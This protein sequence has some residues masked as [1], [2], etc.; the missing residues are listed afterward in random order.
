MALDDWLDVYDAHIPEHLD[1]MQE[2]YGAWL[3][4]TGSVASR[5]D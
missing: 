1:G 3:K 4:A 5:S 2:N